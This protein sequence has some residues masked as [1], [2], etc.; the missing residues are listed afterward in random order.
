MERP[1]AVQMYDIIIII[2][3]IYLFIANESVPGGSGNTTHKLTHVTQI[4]HNTQNY[5]YNKAHVLHTLKHKM[6]I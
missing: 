2:I 6:S 3:I 1:N 5:K 4:T